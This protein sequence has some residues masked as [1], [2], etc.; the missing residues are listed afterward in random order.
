M[1][2]EGPETA[3]EAFETANWRRI[4]PELL[5]YAKGCCTHHG[6]QH[7]ESRASGVLEAEELVNQAV[8]SLLTEARGWVP[9]N[10]KTEKGL[11]A[12]ICMTM[13][14]IAGNARVSHTL[15][16]RTG[17][18]KGERELAHLRDDA[19]DPEAQLAARDLL[20]EVREAITG[21]EEVTMLYGA[22]A[23]GFVKRA[24]V[25]KELHWKVD[26][27]KVTQKR[28]RRMLAS[29]GITWHGTTEHDEDDES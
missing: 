7:R 5:R 20:A 19:P 11:I 4:L 22:Y 12:V 29:K 17:G 14:S 1:A 3:E 28:M 10:A 16:K 15:A 2:Y 18:V 26:K 8:D 24:D 23:E 25:A 13:R 9:A 27:V 21:D 6:F